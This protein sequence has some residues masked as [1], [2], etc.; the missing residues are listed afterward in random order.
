MR[1][2][3]ERKDGTGGLRACGA[4]ACLLLFS[5]ACC[6]RLEEGSR[7][8][9]RGPSTRNC[10]VLSYNA[11]LPSSFGAGWWVR[12]RRDVTDGDGMIS[13]KLTRV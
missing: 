1:S 9:G 13:Q 10:R 2:E 3:D 6:R 5:F 4:P 8:G 7:R 12:D 11:T